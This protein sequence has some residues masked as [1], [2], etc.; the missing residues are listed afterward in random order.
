MRT[1]PVGFCY[2]TVS[3]T[4]DAACDM[5]A[6]THGHPDGIH[7]AGVLAVTV[8]LL[9]DG[10]QLASGLERAAAFAP[11]AA[12]PGRRSATPSTSP[13]PGCPTRSP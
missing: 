13:P 3:Q 9:A 10:E 4:W 8:R 7:P 12:A 5:A 6:I 1:A 2:A 11:A